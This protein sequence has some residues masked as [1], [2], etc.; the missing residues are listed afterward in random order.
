MIEL[1]LPLPSTAQL[2]PV[3]YTLEAGLYAID[4]DFLYIEISD[5][6][7]PEYQG[8]Y[9]S[10][11]FYGEE[12][13]LQGRSSLNA[14]DELTFPEAAA[15]DGASDFA[16]YVW[17]HGAARDVRMRVLE[18][19]DERLRLYISGEADVFWDDDIGANVPFALHAWFDLEG[20]D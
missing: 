13:P 7:K 5:D 14:G 12:V 1:P 6:D 19:K 4:G 11:R 16:V 8:E 9:W 15:P 17:E 3:S 18:K 20:T 10:F 2:G